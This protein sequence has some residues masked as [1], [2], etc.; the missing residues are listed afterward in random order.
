[1]IPRRLI[2][3]ITSWWAARCSQKAIERTYPQ[4]R[5]INRE[6]EEARRKHKAVRPLERQRSQIMRDALKG[7]F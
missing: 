1:M 6:I 4:I 5:S 7:G 2:R 3:R